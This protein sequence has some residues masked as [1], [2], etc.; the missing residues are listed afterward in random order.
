VG[1]ISRKWDIVSGALI[2]F[3]YYLI[4]VVVIPQIHMMLG[5]SSIERGVYI[6]IPLTGFFLG[7]GILASMTRGTIFSFILSA[8]IKILGLISY[9]YLVHDKPIV[10]KAEVGVYGM[11]I[12]ISPEPMIYVVSIWTL[13]TILIDILAIIERL[14]PSIPGTLAYLREA[15]G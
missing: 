10:V 5:A 3:I 4:Y 1:S 8:L 6:D 12:A 13:A 2:G 9:L 7:L 11:A 15:L 14:R